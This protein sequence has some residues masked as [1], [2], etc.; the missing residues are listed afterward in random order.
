MNKVHKQQTKANVFFVT[1]FNLLRNQEKHFP[2][3]DKLKDKTEAEN[4]GVF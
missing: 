3:I 2:M 4:V 1:L